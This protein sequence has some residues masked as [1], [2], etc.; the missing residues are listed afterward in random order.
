MDSTPS[1]PFL[2]RFK[3]P[4]FLLIG[5]AILIGSALILWRK[6][7][8]V[9]IE[10]LPPEPTAIPSATPT[11]GPYLIYLTGAVASP[12]TMVTV[13]YDSR[14]FHALD[15]AGGVAENADLARVN[16]A[17][18]LEDGDQ[19]HV[20]TRVSTDVETAANSN[21]TPTPLMITATPGMVLV[22]VV[23][24]VLQPETMVTLPMLSRVED[25]IKAVGGPTE[26]ADMSRVNLSQ[27]L[28]D[29][30]QIYVPPLEGQGEEIQLPTPNHAPLVHINHATLEELDT[31]PGVGPALAQAIID[32]RTDHGP[33]NS[34]EELDNVSG[35]G[36]A[37]LDNLRDLVVFD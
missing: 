19:I 1:P 31:L 17:Q 3:Y 8:P 10:V 14:V 27:I 12:E 18:K 20:P 15:A 30:D 9:T 29:G 4:I 36:P 37:T 32:Y 22:Y 16:L 28:N 26:N 2:E 6:P 34:L 5:L 35:I 25:A 21:D 7:A 11:P 23:G 13:D 24:E 33:F